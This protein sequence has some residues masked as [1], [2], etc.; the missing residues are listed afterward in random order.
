MEISNLLDSCIF[1]WIDVIVNN[2]IVW[3]VTYLYDVG[4][5]TLP[6]YLCMKF[7]NFYLFLILQLNAHIFYN[8]SWK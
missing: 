1:I 5:D 3:L 7:N 6:R 4:N 2:A 8:K